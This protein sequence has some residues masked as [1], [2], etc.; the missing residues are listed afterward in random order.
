MQKL[1]T[2]SDAEIFLNSVLKENFYSSA[3]KKYKLAGVT[4]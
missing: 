1:Q 2:A 3:N 4:V